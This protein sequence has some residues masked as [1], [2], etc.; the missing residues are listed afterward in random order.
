MSAID[1]RDPNLAPMRRDARGV[2]TTAIERDGRA[3]DCRHESLRSRHARCPD[4]GREKNV[5]LLEMMP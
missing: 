5:A 3:F 1:T 2:Y 4:C